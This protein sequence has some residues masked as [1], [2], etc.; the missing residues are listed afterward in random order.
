MLRPT[1]ED[2]IVAVVLV[3]YFLSTLALCAA[4][5]FVRVR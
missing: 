4:F 5:H 3:L 1:K 2:L